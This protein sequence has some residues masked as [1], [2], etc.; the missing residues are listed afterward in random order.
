[1]ARS[2]DRPQRGSLRKGEHLATARYDLSFTSEDVNSREY[3]AY[4]FEVYVTDPDKLNDLDKVNT[5][6]SDMIQNIG[7]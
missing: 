4:A 2:G 7:D 1:M 5:F 3:L 6:L